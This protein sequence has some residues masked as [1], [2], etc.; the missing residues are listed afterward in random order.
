MATRDVPL[1][2]ACAATAGSSISR[3]VSRS[4]EPVQGALT[5]TGPI[6][7]LPSCKWIPEVSNSPRS[8]GTQFRTRNV[9]CTIRQERLRRIIHLGE[10]HLLVVPGQQHDELCAVRVKEHPQEDPRAGRAGG[11]G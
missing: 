3:T 7:R 4:V 6:A 1:N 2:F 11:S 10:A 5:T 9:G 8:D